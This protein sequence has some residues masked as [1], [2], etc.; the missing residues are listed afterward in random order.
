M[1]T[2]EI[3]MI[4][5]S[6]VPDRPSVSDPDGSVSYSELQ[7]RVNRRAHSLHAL[8]I[9]KGQNV[10]VMA[11]NSNEFVELYYATAAVGATYVPLNFRAKT[12]E[13]QYMADASDVN[14]FFCSERYWPI[15][16]EIRS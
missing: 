11:V 2:A 9:G 7:S 12:E 14:I 6:M 16:Q 13:L 1:N 3:L 8:G 15:L 4:A 5:G 10:G